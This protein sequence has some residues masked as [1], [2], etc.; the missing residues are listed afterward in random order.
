MKKFKI[1][2][3]DGGGIRG[4]FPAKYLSNIETRL[5]EEGYSGKIYEH[6][7]LICGTST[8]GILALGLALGIPSN[9]L[10]SLYFEN[11]KKIFPRSINFLLRRKYSRKSLDKLI[12]E[13]FKNAFDGKSNP[14]IKDL[15]TRV[16]ITG[17]DIENATPKVYK[18]PHSDKYKIDKHRLVYQVALSTAAAPTYFSPFNGEYTIIDSET[19][20]TFPLT[21]DGGVFANNPTLI[22]IIEAHKGL[23]I[24]LED[25]E[26]IS[27]G[28]GTEV[29]SETNTKTIL[30]VKYPNLWGSFYWINKV[31]IL[32][33]IMQAQSQHIHNLCEILS[34]G[35]GEVKKEIFPY[36]RI[37]ITL[38]KNL[39]IAMDTTQKGKLQALVNKAQSEFQNNGSEIVNLITKHK[40]FGGYPQ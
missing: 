4:V 20:E 6:F 18:T 21:V 31:R 11:S 35:T 27:I 34:G 39:K 2:S 14:R 3:I 38:D 40:K 22:G 29:F 15:K 32:N 13:K 7:D 17:Y 28:T 19:I 5:K 36:K 16:C 12:K 25:I 23:N 24:P 33:L 8:G 37:Q 1:L 30:G 10:L 26:V 9:E